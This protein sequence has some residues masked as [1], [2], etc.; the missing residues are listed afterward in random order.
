VSYGIIYKATGPTGKVYVGQTTQTL[1]SRKSAHKYMAMKKDR[2]FA[3]QSALLD[4]GF[5]NFTWEQIDAAETAEELDQK[6]KQWIAHYDSTN[7]ERGY[8]GTEGGIK[9]VYSPEARQRISEALKG[10]KNHIGKRHTAESR[11]KM[12]ELMKGNKN[13]LGKHHSIETR[14]KMS[15]ALK[16]RTVS[17]ETR[18]KL[19][20]ARKRNGHQATAKKELECV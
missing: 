16:G 6:E 17:A 8:N 13:N 7:P 12:S 1:K 3:F 10:N 15:E 9:T 4:N 5:S 14:Q 19:S 18:R 11:R 20:E 2:R